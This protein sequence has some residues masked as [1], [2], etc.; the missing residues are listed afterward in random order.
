LYLY[1]FNL[2]LNICVFLMVL[3]G[4]AV[5]QRCTKKTR[6]FTKKERNEWWV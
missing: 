4:I 3:Y 6:S 2:G 1:F 5:T